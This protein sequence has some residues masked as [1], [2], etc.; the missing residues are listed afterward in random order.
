MGREEEDQQLNRKVDDVRPLCYVIAILIMLRRCLFP[1]S[2]LF[3]LVEVGVLLLSASRRS[4]R[5]GGY[6]G[7]REGG[8]RL[9]RSLGDSSDDA[10][11]GFGGRWTIGTTAVGLA[12][13]VGGDGGAFGGERSV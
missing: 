2:E 5:R 10:L 6:R 13:V 7:G 12:S 3:V 11:L 9:Q 4:S 1:A 8:G